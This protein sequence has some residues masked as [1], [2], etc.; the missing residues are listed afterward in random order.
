MKEICHF[1][2]KEQTSSEADPSAALWV[3]I[4]RGGRRDMGELARFKT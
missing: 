2:V 4:K 3:L 1:R